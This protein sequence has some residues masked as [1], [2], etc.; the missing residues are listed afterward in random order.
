MIVTNYRNGL[1]DLGTRWCWTDS[2][3]KPKG[4]DGTCLKVNEPQ[5]WMTF[6]EALAKTSETSGRTLGLLLNPDDDLVCIDLDDCLDERGNIKDPAVRALVDM[7]DSYTEVSMSGRGLH[8]F[9]KSNLDLRVPTKGSPEIYDGERPRYIAVT[10]KCYED[11]RAVR[12]S[13][14]ALMRA[15]E[16]N[17]TVRSSKKQSVKNSNTI[18]TEIHVKSIEEGVSLALTLLSQERCDDR[19]EWFKA[20]CA[21][22]AALGEDGREIF[23][24]WSQG[25][26]FYD[27]F[28][29]SYQWESIHEPEVTLTTLL[30]MAFEDSG[31]HIRIPQEEQ[32]VSSLMKLVENSS[33][34]IDEIPDDIQVEWLV[35]G[36][37][38]KGHHTLLSRR[39]KSGKSTLI[40][41][42]LKP[43]LHSNGGQFLGINIEG[44]KKIMIITEET[45]IQWKARRELHDM[46]GK[47]TICSHPFGK[48]SLNEW[49]LLCSEL[50]VK[51]RNEGYDLLIIDPLAYFSSWKDE[52]S[53]TETTNAMV[54]LDAFKREGIALLSLHHGA[55]SSGQARGSSAITSIPDINLNLSYPRKKVDNFEVDDIETSDRFLKGQGRF[56][57]VPK[58]LRLG[59]NEYLE[60]YEIKLSNQEQSKVTTKS[61]ILESLRASI[62]PLTKKCINELLD[63]PLA[64]ASLRRYLVQMVESEELLRT[65]SGNQSDPYLFSINKE[66]NLGLVD[67]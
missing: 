49:K 47:L 15:I 51:M 43:M 35:L 40:G 25:S 33:Y 46:K 48:P 56:P 19:T 37:I 44:D 61:K 30:K 20:M 21:S 23:D 14:E 17:G 64:E 29:N 31:V 63:Q 12:T 6:K 24:A 39:E 42:M 2:T 7:A 62:K 66:Y 13:D 5:D 60:T 55:K 67:F 11:F 28:E 45:Q 9:I 27:E 34:T 32:G 8:V 54:P 36:I 53:S 10:G 26:E 57:G 50:A 16:L 18:K 52:N 38:A 65:G 1:E 59:F 58:K 3:K 22:K 41:G 4:L